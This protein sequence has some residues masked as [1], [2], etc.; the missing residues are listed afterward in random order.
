MSALPEDV[1]ARVDELYCLALDR[2]VAERDALA[3]ELRGEKR[4]EEAA[5]VAKLP[6]PAVAAWAVNQVVR[7]QAKAAR[8]LWDAGDAVLAVQRRAV[9]G[10]AA[11]DELR[12]AIA[13]QRE[14]LTPL[15]DAA[16]GMLTGRGA[17][18]GE[19]AVQAVIETLHA[20]AVDPEARRDVEAGRLARPL[21]LAGLGA[22]PAGP[23]GRRADGA[24]EA[25]EPE[26]EA[27][28]APPAADAEEAKAAKRREAQ[29]AKRRAAAAAK[30][31]AA[32]E[33]AV[34]GARRARE[35]ALQRVERRRSELEAAEAELA[36]LDEELEAAEAALGDLDDD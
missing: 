5:A 31:R 8:A 6:K 28:E 11:G 35:T 4:R 7:S 17:F 21:R 29:E 12:A 9:A 14:A 22:F 10:E 13:G 24:K 2:F 15:A 18:L 33:R 16:R 36:R 26:P 1:E 3:R 25:A 20:A 34:A 32:A 19:Q 23:A 30:Q 27:A